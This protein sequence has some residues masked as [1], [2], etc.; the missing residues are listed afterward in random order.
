MRHHGFC[1]RENGH[2]NLR[3]FVSRER[4]LNMNH[5]VVD[6][7]LS[8][9]PGCIYNNSFHDDS[10]M[11]AYAI[12]HCTSLMYTLVRWIH[13]VVVPCS[14]SYKR[15]QLPPEEKHSVHFL[16]QEQ[17]PTCLCREVIRVNRPTTPFRLGGDM[18]EPQ[19]MRTDF[20]SL[21]HMI[22]LVLFKT[23]CI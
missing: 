10:Y 18:I 11:S 19:A 13:L 6:L 16:V 23:A 2:A 1:T 5:V 14:S 15:L 4:S 7:R 9:S 8:A 21:C 22:G 3:S 17:L 20:V 12:V